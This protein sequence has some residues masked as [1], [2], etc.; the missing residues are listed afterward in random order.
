MRELD[1]QS[2]PTGARLAESGAIAV[3]FIDHPDWST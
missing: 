1:M 2:E 3:V